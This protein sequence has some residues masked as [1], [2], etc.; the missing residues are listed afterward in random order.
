MNTFVNQSMKIL[1]RIC[2]QRPSWH[3]MTTINIHQLENEPLAISK[4]F[5][6]STD[7]SFY[8]DYNCLQ[9]RYATDNYELL[10]SLLLRNKMIAIAPSLVFYNWKDRYLGKD[11]IQIP[12][13]GCSTKLINFL[14][15]K[16][17]SFLNPVEIAA[18]DFY[19]SF[20][21]ILLIFFSKIQ[22][23]LNQNTILLQHKKPCTQ[24]LHT[25]LIF[26][27]FYPYLSFPL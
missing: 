1:F 21:V 8:H 15:Y 17:T 18:L 10:K 19:D 14:I 20:I 12:L 22:T 23:K 9:K 6:A 2:T 16:N 25:W 5:L 7:N 26:I 24:S 4:L 3:E 27:P 13:T 11:I